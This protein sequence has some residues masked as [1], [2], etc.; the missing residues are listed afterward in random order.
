MRNVRKQ[1]LNGEVPASCTKC[2]KEEAAGHR[3]K[4]QWETAFTGVSV[5]M[6]TTLSPIQK[7]TAKYLPT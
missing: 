5:L 6:L 2:F 3:S 7:P 4:R 1:M